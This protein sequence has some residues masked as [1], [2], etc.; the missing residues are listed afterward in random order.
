MNCPPTL[1]AKSIVA[2]PWKWAP[3]VGL[4]AIFAVLAILGCHHG[5]H[6]YSDAEL[7]GAEFLESFRYSG[8]ALLESNPPGKVVIVKADRMGKYDEATGQFASAIAD[9]MKAQT[10]F[11]VVVSTDYSCAKTFDEIVQGKFLEPE[12]V[13]TALQYNADAVML[14]RVNHWDTHHPM[15]IS[16]SVAMIDANEA[17]VI[18]AA[19]GVWDLNDRATMKNFRKRLC[20]QSVDPVSLKIRMR[21]PIRFL[22]YVAQQVTDAMNF[23]GPEN[24]LDWYW[25]SGG[26]R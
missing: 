9:A 10:K 14:V 26:N 22:S 23:A 7:D 24:A 4:L 18:F 21:S 8:S 25:D 17:V 16:I 3:R 6:S 11:E 2:C 5:L 12:L 19:D 1:F 15:T 13:K 20:S